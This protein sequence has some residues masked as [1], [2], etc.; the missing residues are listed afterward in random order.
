MGHGIVLCGQIVDHRD[1]REPRQT[2]R[3]PRRR[4]SFLSVSTRM[5][6]LWQLET[7]TRTQVGQTLDRI[8]PQD[9]ARLVDHLHFFRRVAFVLQ[10]ADLRNDVEG[11]RM[12]ERLVGIVLPV[13]RGRVLLDQLAR[14]GESPAPLVA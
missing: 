10:R 3:G 8:V 5:L 6:S 12:G 9:L 13:E 2:A 7:G 1:A 14:A 4:V 11:D